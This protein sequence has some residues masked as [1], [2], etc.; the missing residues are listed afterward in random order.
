MPKR[1]LVDFIHADYLAQFTIKGTVLDNKRGNPVPEAETYFVDKGLDYV[2]SRNPS[3]WIIYIGKTDS[4]GRFALNFDYTWGIV[5]KSS[6]PPPASGTFQI[7][8]QH[9]GYRPYQ[10]E[11]SMAKLQRTGNHDIVDL[12]TVRLNKF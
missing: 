10:A 4:N 7:R 3:R 1:K 11:F 5:T 9:K 8:V 12:G 2:R 6:K